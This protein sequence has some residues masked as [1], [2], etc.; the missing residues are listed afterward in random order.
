MKINELD[1]VITFEDLNVSDE[2]VEC[3]LCKAQ[4]PNL[5][6]L[7]MCCGAMMSDKNTLYLD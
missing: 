5:F 6:D 4:M 7:C 1:S 3:N 2:I